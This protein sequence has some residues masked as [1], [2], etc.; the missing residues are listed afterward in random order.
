MSDPCNS[1]TLAVAAT[2]AVSNAQNVSEVVLVRE[3]HHA[4]ETLLSRIAAGILLVVLLSACSNRFPPY[5]R[6][7]AQQ[8]QG[9]VSSIPTTAPPVV[10]TAGACLP[11]IGTLGRQTG[12]GWTA[13]PG[14][15]PDVQ[16]FYSGNP[17]VKTEGFSVFTARPPSGSS[18]TVTSGLSSNGSCESGTVEN[19]EVGLISYVCSAVGSEDPF[20]LLATDSRVIQL[21]TVAVPSST[22]ADRL[23]MAFAEELVRISS[24]Q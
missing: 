15:I 4:R 3:H 8:S 12:I 21:F 7:D 20:G 13:V 2:P 11:D 9:N 1:A 17:N 24:G 19:L 16:C 6:G 23:R 22:T 18:V 10:Q 14:D 5:S